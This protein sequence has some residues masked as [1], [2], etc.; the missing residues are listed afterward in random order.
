LSSILNTTIGP[1][2]SLQYTIVGFNGTEIFFG[3]RDAASAFSSLQKN[4]VLPNTLTNA[5]INWSGQL[6]VNPGNGGVTGNLFLNTDPLSFTKTLNNTGAQ[7][8]GGSI[9]SVHPGGASIDTIL[10]LLD[11]NGAATTLATVGTAFL[12]STTGHFTI[13]TVSAVPVPAAVVLFATGIIGLIGVAR[14]KVFGV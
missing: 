10:N 4:Q 9:P 1:A 3:D 11:R 14:R 13:G 8:L 6:S 12:S 5:L 2:S 7:T